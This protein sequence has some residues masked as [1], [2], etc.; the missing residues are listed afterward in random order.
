MNL[1]QWTGKRFCC[2]WSTARNFSEEKLM[3]KFSIIYILTV[4]VLF[5]GSLA[6][7]EV[8]E[9]G[10]AGGG[11]GAL[12]DPVEVY[13]FSD[14]QPAID[15]ACQHEEYDTIIVHPGTYEEDL[16]INCD[17]LTIAS[18]D[19][20]S[21]T[22][23]KGVANVDEGDWP[24]VAPNIEI[25]GNDVEICGFTIQGPDYEAMKYSSGMVIGGDNVK[26]HNNIFQPTNANSLNE[27]SQAIQTYRDGNGGAGD[28]NGL[29]IY[30][31]TIEPLAE[32]T[33]G[34]EAIF[35]NHTPSDPEPAGV[36]SIHHN[37]IIG[38]VVRGITTE[39]SNVVIT[40]NL[41][42]TDL[43]HFNGE[44]GALQGIL[45]QD[46]GGREQKNVTVTYNTVRGFSGFN[47]GI[48]VGAASQVLSGIAIQNN[49]ILSN[50]VGIQVRSAA[51]VAVNNNKIV[52]NSMGVENTD[53]VEL[54]ATLNWWNDAAGPYHPVTNPG[55][56]GDEVSD[57]VD[58][59]PWC[60]DENCGASGIHPVENI[61]KLITYSTIQGAIDDADEGDTIVASAGTYPEYLHITT[62]GLTIEGAGIDASIID[63]NG[64]E[65]YWHYD[66]S[67]SYASRAGVLISGYG[68][69][70]EVVEDVTFRGFTVKNVG[71]NPPI[72][73]SGTHTGPNDMDVLMD[74]SASWTP[75]ELEDMWI[76]NYGDRDTDYSPVRSYGQITANTAT[77]VTATLS[78]GLE[79]DWDTGDTYVITSYKHYYIGVNGMGDG[80]EQIIGICVANSKNV[81]IENCKAENC[82]KAGISAT[83]ARCVSAHKYSEG[84]TVNNCISQNN[85]ADGIS[86][87][88]YSGP[89]TITN[90][91]CSDNGCPHVADPTR[92]YTGVGIDVQ[93]T[94][95]T[96]SGTI[97]NNTCTDNGFEGIIV[98]GN[99]DGVIE[100]VNV[101]SNIVT[102]HNSDQDGAGIF[103]YSS[104]WY[105]GYDKCQN[106]IVKNNTVTGNIR[107][108]VAYNAQLCTFEDNEITTDS[109]DFDSGQP[110]IK[111]DGGNNIVV[112]NNSI[113][114]CDG[115]GILV[116]NMWDGV[117]ESHDNTITGN[118]ISDAKFAG[119]AIWSGAYDNT[120]TDN[121]ITGTTELTF[122]EGESYEETQA[123]GVFID[124]DAGSGNV[125]TCNRI[126]DN[127]GDGM[128]NQTAYMVD[129]ENNWWGSDT[130]P[131]GVGGGSGDEVS[132][133]VDYFPWLLSPEDCGDYTQ[134]APDLVVDDDWAGLPDFTQVFVG[135]Q[136]YYISL[137]AFDDIQ[138][139]VDAATDGN[140]VYVY[141][142]NYSPFT[143]DGKTNLTI[144]AGSSPVV[145]GVQ[146]VNTNYG[147]RDCVVFV[148]NSVNIVQNMLDIQGDGLGTINTKNYGVIYQSSSGSVKD[149]TVSPNTAGDMYSTAIG[150][151]DG[152]VVSVMTTL[153]ENYGRIGILV[154]N[155]TDAQILDNEIVGQVYADEG[156][157]CYGIE[158][159]GISGTSDPATASSAIIK[160]NEIYNCDNTFEPEP[161]WTSSGIYIN[162]WKAYGDEAD[163]TATIIDNIIHDNYEGIGV[164]DSPTSTANFNS[165]YDNRTAGVTC[166]AAADDSNSVF[167]AEY[168][169]WGDI[170]GPNDPNGTIETDGS[171][172]CPAVEEIKNA[173]GLGNKV[174]E[175]VLYCPWLLAPVSSSAYPLLVG[176]L[177]FDGD[178]DFAD[179]ALFANNWLV[180]TEE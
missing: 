85:A 169:W 12:G 122:W 51:G 76:H 38:T 67:S 160:R 28:L 41:V 11:A 19:G 45:L 35:I 20:N 153:I 145:T 140:S 44:V 68:S 137:N 151:W 47:Q 56:S 63:M 14:L 168:N 96:V 30:Y 100:D 80:R 17:G 81:L 42:E 107:G 159:E 175:N 133:N 3:K 109:G 93:S 101:S 129:A 157:V 176:D 156:Q 31:N 49:S 180:G 40:G 82:G 172:I 79:N 130:G 92:E 136:D 7:A 128:E 95:D 36:V 174:T 50:N 33:H 89:V 134:L 5:T 112:K 161:S 24:L 91:T 171:T 22:F 48:R 165:I 108:L 77:T 97:F 53:A 124:D 43:E 74:A 69:D 6:Q 132:A 102:G 158:V 60:T 119:I 4:L 139:A 83:K 118:T 75:G 110:A 170:S 2:G 162:G 13:D 98:R 90:N 54:D 120:F 163:S 115:V 141:D 62:D 126:H 131:G 154:Y 135:S 16:V 18:T 150:I 164:V 78:G 37:N 179:L 64:L 104:E 88:N 46:F 166:A 103:L 52:G 123:D 86:V 121:T 21:V 25:T 178:V 116:Q 71:L 167:D 148:N 127:D 125:F 27:I 147:A 99:D 29:E 58:Y 113:S 70:D 142:G 32:G 155:N 1:C 87:G 34:I 59:D 57:N 106:I 72:I 105:G 55:S 94:E 114:S 152:S 15:Y 144:T 143:V 9:V 117:A 138:G 146:S 111:V 177:D 149:C 73:A 26:I 65:P 84:L 10:P 8:L 173:D 61:T 39:R 66:C 23:I